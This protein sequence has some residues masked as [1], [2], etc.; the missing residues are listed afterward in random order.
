MRCDTATRPARSRVV[1]RAGR[2]HQAGGEVVLEHVETLERTLSGELVQVDHLCGPIGS[3]WTEQE[4]QA[5]FGTGK[6][7]R[8][9]F[10]ATGIVLWTRTT[11]EVAAL[12]GAVGT[13]PLLRSSLPPI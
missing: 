1:G 6:W 9:E 3:H 12:P 5:R 4:I 11:G 13:S 7:V 8:V 2:W 10:P